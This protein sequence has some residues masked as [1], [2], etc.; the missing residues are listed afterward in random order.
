MSQP[1][2]SLVHAWRHPRPQGAE[3]RCIGARTDL[4]VDPRRAKRLAHRIRRVA[5]LHELPRMVA[6]SPLRR[7]ADVGRW[8][9][10]WGWQHRIDA[11]LAE[12]DFGAW[13]GR[14]W[15]SI[16]VAE[17]DAWCADLARY[18]PGGGEPLQVLLKRVGAW[19]P[20]GIACI[21]THGG[22]MLARRWLDEHA[23][24]VP[25]AA[26]WPAAPGYGERLVLGIPRTKA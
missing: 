17:I 24:R 23:D 19:Q 25:T 7:C 5:R 16:P 9:K 3:G 20:E 18:V 22:W 8:L 4:A 10:R 11:A 26:D 6:T 14:A 12:V 15:S 1:I 13:D 2:H 21:V